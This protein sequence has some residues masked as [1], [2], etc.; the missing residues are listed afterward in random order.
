MPSLSK[1]L[2]LVAIISAVWFGF[3]L[4]SQ[5]DRQR[6]DVA[7]KEKERARGQRPPPRQVDDMVKCDVCGTFIAR[8][9]TG[10]GKPTCPF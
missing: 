5:L 8:G 6:R 1:I 2:I 7:R 3:R 9:S 10:C 4:L